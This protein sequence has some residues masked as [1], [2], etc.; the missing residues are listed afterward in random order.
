MAFESLA[1]AAEILP[2]HARILMNLIACF[3][4]D[5]MY[6]DTATEEEFRQRQI[7]NQID[8]LLDMTGKT[9][10]RKKWYLPVA[11][12]VL[13]FNELYP[14]GFAFPFILKH[15]P[16]AIGG[17]RLVN[18]GNEREKRFEEVPVKGRVMC[19]CI[20][21]TGRGNIAFGLKTETCA[22]FI[23]YIE[24]ALTGALGRALALLGFGTI[25]ALKEGTVVDAPIQSDLP[26]RQ[27]KRP[28][29]IAAKP[30]QT[31][32]PSVKK[33]E[34]Q[35]ET[36]QQ[37][38]VK[39]VSGSSPEEKVRIYHYQ[40]SSGLPAAAKQW[41]E[42]DYEQALKLAHVWKA[43]SPHTPE[44]ATALKG[45]IEQMNR[46]HFREFVGR[47]C[48]VETMKTNQAQAQFL[49]DVFGQEIEF[50]LAAQAL[51][52]NFTLLT[53]K[54]YELQSPLDFVLPQRIALK[55]A[56]LTYIAQLKA[57]WENW[58]RE[59]QGA[60]PEEACIELFSK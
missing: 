24:K 39:L 25:D 1:Q 58:D 53:K 14:R 50:Y 11:S 60:L 44:Q 7:P 22:D 43:L 17:T 52:K 13:A 19:G 48:G 5:F 21:F 20:V 8:D 56:K 2:E 41:T 54:P 16:E 31:A 10:G 37:Q 34:T 57:L 12:R 6:A 4:P 27:L 18:V 47:V 51:D 23:D 42:A 59:Q 32:V 55:A 38:L 3:G 26:A 15:E 46:V 30:V 36:A 49:L 29:A 9:P 33:E 40:V 28:E 45:Y 35:P